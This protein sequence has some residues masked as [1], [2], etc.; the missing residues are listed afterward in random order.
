M[1]G[2][3]WTDYVVAGGFGCTCLIPEHPSPFGSMATGFFSKKV[4]RKNAAMEAAQF[5]ISEGLLNPDKNEV[6]IEK[7]DA[8]L[9]ADSYATRVNGMC[10]LS[11][12]VK[13][14]STSL[15]SSF[16]F[17]KKSKPSFPLH[18]MSSSQAKYSPK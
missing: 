11:F 14:R 10:V 5:L 12:I 17:Q 2:P 13:K 16:S 9:S 15:I 6:K 4:A 3:V 7:L 1:G 18:Q 8:I